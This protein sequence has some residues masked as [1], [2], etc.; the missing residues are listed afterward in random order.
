MSNVFHKSITDYIGQNEFRTSFVFAIKE[1]TPA[2]DS[3]QTVIDLKYFVNNEQLYQIKV[4][5]KCCDL[6]GVYKATRAILKKYKKSLFMLVGGCMAHQ[7]NI[8]LKYL[9][10]KCPEVKKAIKSATM[11]ATT[12]GQSIAFFTSG[13]LTFKSLRN[14]F[15]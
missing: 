4:L 6:A 2:T 15:V 9:N 14:I 13:H 1:G 7:T 12:L 3:K 8:F 5:N 11:T 10:V